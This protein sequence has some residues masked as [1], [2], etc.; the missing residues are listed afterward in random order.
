[1]RILYVTDALAIWG[2]IERI[3]VEK[4]NYLAEYYGCD[5]YFITVNQGSH[6]ILFPLSSKVCYKDLDIEELMA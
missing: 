5:V 3:L 4:A 1:M 6:P 2:G